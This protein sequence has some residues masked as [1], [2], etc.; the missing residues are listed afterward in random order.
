MRAGTVDIF[1]T[2]L[3][4]NIGVPTV[5]QCRTVD[6]TLSNISSAVVVVAEDAA[7]LTRHGF[8]GSALGGLP[9]WA[10]KFATK[11]LEFIEMEERVLPEK[12]CAQQVCRRLGITALVFLK[13]SV[14]DPGKPSV[15][16]AVSRITAI[17]V[18]FCGGVRFVALLPTRSRMPGWR[19]S[20]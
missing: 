13:G 6:R 8:K 2:A 5:V 17:R 3:F 12:L 14:F 19:R 1:R 18:F 10:H 16:F 20:V 9:M 4:H 7:L 11:I 15:F